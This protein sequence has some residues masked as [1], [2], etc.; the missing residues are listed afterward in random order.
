KGKPEEDAALRLYVLSLLLERATADPAR[1]LERASRLALAVEDKGSVRP[2]EI[3]FM[4]AIQ[5]HRRRSQDEVEPWRPDWKVVQLALQVRQLA[6]QAALGSSSEDHWP[7]YSDQLNPWIEKA[8]V[9]ADKYRRKG[10]DLMFATGKSKD[11]I[12]ALT[13]AQ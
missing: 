7:A 3:H 12:D 2:A 13:N 11:A 1:Y 5:E 4:V 6:E 9:E 8:V 10:E